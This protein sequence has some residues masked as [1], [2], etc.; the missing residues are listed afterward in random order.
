MDKKCKTPLMSGSCDLVFACFVL[1]TIQKRED[2]LAVLNEISRC[3]AK[4]GVLIVV[5]ASDIFYSHQWLSYNTNYLENQNLKTSDATKFYLKDLD[6]ELK[7][8]YWTDKNNREFFKSANLEVVE[9]LSPKGLVDD[10]I[11]W[12]S[13]LEYA[14]YLIYVLKNTKV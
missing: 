13:E 5:I 7:N 6:V 1:C 9:R 11:S 10:G 14:P 2:L 4:D 3:L 8:Y 12:V